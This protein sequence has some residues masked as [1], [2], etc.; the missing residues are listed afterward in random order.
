[1][2]LYPDSLADLKE[3][4]DDKNYLKE[5]LNDSEEYLPVKRVNF[6]SAENAIE[7]YNQTTAEDSSDEDDFIDAYNESMQ[8]FQ[9]VRRH[10]W[11]TRKEPP[12]S[13]NLR[14]TVYR[15]ALGTVKKLMVK[16]QNPEKRVEA[17][18]L[19]N[20]MLT[21]AWILNCIIACFWTYLSFSHQLNME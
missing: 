10:V 8:I 6:D 9:R 7:N 1:M 15:A 18:H 5:D 3:D 16:I 13:F 12:K 20:Y 2:S 19:I 11:W 4:D 14:R 21:L 17:L